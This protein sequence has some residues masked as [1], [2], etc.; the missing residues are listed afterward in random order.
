MLIRTLLAF[1][2]TTA[3][4]AQDYPTR[5]IKMIVPYAAGGAADLMGRVVAQKLTEALPHPVVVE[6]RGGAGGN[7]GADMVAKATPD[8]Y[9]L[10]MGNAPTLA[11]N[12]SLF[13]KLP[14]DPA[15]DFSPVSLV[16]AVP[17]ILLVHPAQP[18]HSVR[19]VIEAARAKPGGLVY[20]SGGNGSTTHL[21][22]E[23]L[24]SMTGTDIIPIP[25]NGSAPAIIAITNGEV[26]LMMD[27][28]PSSIAQV[29]AGR[30]RALAISTA[31]RSALLPELPTVAESGVP[32]FEVSSWF[33][34]VAPA[35]TPPAIVERLNREIVRALAMADTRERLASL[36]AEPVG[37][38]AA[39]FG[40]YIKSELVKWAAVV[41]ASGAHVE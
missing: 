25:F 28:I 34:V 3:A 41:K 35:G 26:P 39:A 20:A 2:V 8:G 36:G 7:I 30:L 18:M 12:A 21:S 32:G 29:K 16:A 38:T 33:G 13:T 22:M 19:D 10:L 6:N 23:L 5:P 27:L 1:L 9:T 40:A 31:T 14:Y 17:L 11:I 15:K 24:K 37:N 4:T